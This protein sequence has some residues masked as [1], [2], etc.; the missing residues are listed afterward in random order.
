[1][2]KEE[3]VLYRRK[4]CWGERRRGSRGKSEGRWVSA[5]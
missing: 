2:G 5:F 3:K 1:M 4:D